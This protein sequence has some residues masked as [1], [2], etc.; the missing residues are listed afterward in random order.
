M[1]ITGN[2]N[3]QKTYERVPALML[4]EDGTPSSYTVK[5]NRVETGET[6]EEKNEFVRINVTVLEAKGD[7]ASPV[8][9]DAEIFILEQKFDYAAKEVAQFLRTIVP[10]ITDLE[11]ALAEASGP[12]QPLAGRIIGVSMRQATNKKT[13][14]KKTFASGEPVPERSY[15]TVKGKTMN[16][17]TAVVNAEART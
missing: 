1:A 5:I 15:F 10:T 6:F 4:G 8:G 17:K 11:K 13:G 7:G 3:N 2:L 9:E 14:A 12:T 16:A